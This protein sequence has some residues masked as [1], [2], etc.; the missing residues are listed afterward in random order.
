MEKEANASLLSVAPTVK[1]EGSEAGETLDAAWASLP[2]ATARKTPAETTAADALLTAVDLLPPRDM[3]ATAPLGQ[4]RV[5]ASVATKLI[6][7]M[8]PELVPCVQL[9]NHSLE[10]RGRSKRTEPLESSTLTA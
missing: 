4:L 9:V 2:A 5:F 8:T 6:P 3:L 10:Y 7:A 1:T